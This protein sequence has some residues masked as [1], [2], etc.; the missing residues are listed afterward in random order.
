MIA[1]GRIEFGLARGT[2]V[3]AIQ[4]GVNR[5]FG[6]AG[7]A[8]DGFVVP[9]IQGP[10]LDRMVRQREMAIFAGIVNAAAL[11]FDC[12]N[13]HRLV[14]MGAPGLGIDIHPTNVWNIL[15]HVETGNQTVSSSS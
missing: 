2:T 11:H 15:A 1:A 14:V 7:S 9:F 8:Q 10:H 3:P 5:Q 6:A 13:I 12:D 4:V